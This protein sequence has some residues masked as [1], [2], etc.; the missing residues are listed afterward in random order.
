MAE[1]RAGKMVIVTDDANRENE[2]DLVMA[3]EKVTPQA[4]NFMAKH[5]RG[6]ICV[7][8]T[9][10]RCQELRLFPMG[11][12]P[13]D[14]F[15]TAFTISVDARH[16]ISTGISAFDRAETILVIADAK[17][18]FRDIVTPGHVFPLQARDGGVL[19][20]AGHTEAAVD[21][22]GLAGLIPAGVICEIMNDDGS[23]ARL[24]DLIRF[25]E[26][27][28][29]KMVSIAQL[30]EYRRKKERL[31]E[32][33]V[34]TQLP[35]PYGVFVLH[36]Y[37]SKIDDLIHLAFV[38]GDVGDGRSM[39][40][41]VHS[42]CLTGDVFNSHRCDCGKQL[43]AA[44]ERIGEEQRGILLYLR[45]EGRGIGLI[46]KLKAYALQD[47]GLDTVEAN[48]KLGFDVDLR[49][50]GIGAQILVDLGVREL[51]LMTNNPRKLVGLEG[52]GMKVVERVPLKITANQHNLEY[53]KAKVEK[54]GH[55]I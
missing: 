47:Q 5:G 42:E 41:R 30:I 1:I 24:P 33:V 46:N 34:S 25:K 32:K 26:A 6:L 13:N 16:G 3:A 20:R 51:R 23:M 38:M 39:L 2:G 19:N 43:A 29:L 49:E 37:E 31:I 18:T 55:L 45:Q 52:Y 27:H 44:L 36:A 35:T 12:A 11:E 17:K 53:L 54:L 4:V 48:R 28:Q 14:V 8:I 21:L 22:T 7:P 15:R 10:K 9:A 40:T 50:Y